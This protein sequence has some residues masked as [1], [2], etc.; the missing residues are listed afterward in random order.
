[1][2][3]GRSGRRRRPRPG[4]R[5]ARIAHED[6][7][8]RCRRGGSPEDRLER[9]LVAARTALEEDR[10]GRCARARRGGARRGPRSAPPCTTGGRARAAGADRRGAGR[11]PAALEVGKNDPELL[12][13]A[14]RFLV[15]GLP[16][17]EQE[18]VDLEAGLAA[19]RRGRRLA[20]RAGEPTWRRAVPGRGAGALASS[21]ARRGARCAWPAPSGSRRATRRCCGSRDWRSRSCAGSR[22]RAPPWLAAEAAAAGRPLDRARAGAPGRA[23]GRRRGGAP[24]VRPRAQ[25]RPRGVP[26]APS[27]SR[28]RLRG[29]V[30]DALAELPE[31][32]APLSLQRGHHRRG[33]AFGRR[34]ARRATRPSPPASSASSAGRPA[35]QKA[36]MDPWSHLPSSIVLYQRNLE[37]FAREPRRADR[38]D[39]A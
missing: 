2:R 3:A 28:H 17:E 26:R 22:R 20:E 8:R 9:L 12:L 36:S 27:P 23:P 37:R 29:G 35:G 21:E 5:Q 33:P 30:E 14:A 24:A 7:W 10:A 38:G 32:R 25:A 15:D 18:R 31:P 6:R 16:E 39:P 11:L 13:G 4:A 19:R 34:P 1:M